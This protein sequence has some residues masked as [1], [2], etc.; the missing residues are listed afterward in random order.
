M[1]VLITCELVFTLRSAEISQQDGPRI[2]NF[3][4]TASTF[5][6]IAIRKEQ[7]LVQVNAHD[8]FDQY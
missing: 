8:R 1:H 7:D 2:T 3:R 5:R 6:V 4:E